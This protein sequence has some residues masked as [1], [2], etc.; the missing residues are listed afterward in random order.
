MKLHITAL[1]ASALTATLTLGGCSLP[2]G[3]GGMYNDSTPSAAD[4]SA[5]FDSAD[6]NSADEMFV[7]MMIP[8]HEQALEMADLILAHDG[9]D[10]RV[11]DLAERIKAAQQPEIDLMT[12]W[13]DAPG[14][15]MGNMGGMDHN[16]G[17][18]SDDDMSALEAADG[19]AAVS[20]FLQLMIEHHEGAIDMAEQVLDNGT[21]VD[22]RGLAERII[23]S[24]TAE[25]V[26]MRGILG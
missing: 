17:M 15:D 22:V 8:H 24:Q 12:G 25:I 16:E 23:E 19:A 20:L 2:G 7:V 3:M 9:I 1:V 14:F 10:E 21:N 11:V 26:E 18:M 6:F 5:D 13:L 4:D